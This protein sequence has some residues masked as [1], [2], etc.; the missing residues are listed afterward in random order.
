MTVTAD[1]QSVVPDWVPRLL[2]EG[3]ELNPWV[4][5]TDA[6]PYLPMPRAKA[7]RACEKYLTRLERERKRRHS[8]LLPADSLLARDGELPCEGEGRS[9][10]IS[11]RFLLIKLCGFLP[12]IPGN[13]P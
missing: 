8:Y 10:V 9:I 11:K 12:L 13:Q 7:Y 1:V 4:T 6:L 3:G 2:A 5:V